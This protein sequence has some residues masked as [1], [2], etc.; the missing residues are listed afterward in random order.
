LVVL[1]SL[2][3]VADNLWTLSSRPLC[4]LRISSIFLILSLLARSG[5]EIQER[6]LIDL[7]LAI[8]AINSWNRLAIDFKTVPRTFQ[9]GASPSAEAAAPGLTANTGH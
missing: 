4:A 7:T 3:P 5:I 8:V 9:V 2:E 6:E 1:G